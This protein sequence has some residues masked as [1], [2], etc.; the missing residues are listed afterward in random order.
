MNIEFPGLNQAELAVE[1]QYIVW[2]ETQELYIQ[3]FLEAADCQSK[4]V[5]FFF[6]SAT[7]ILG[8]QT[9]MVSIP[10]YPSWPKSGYAILKNWS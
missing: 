9:F 7:S 1:T 10:R 3:L 2:V 6:L 5:I 4:H 8:L